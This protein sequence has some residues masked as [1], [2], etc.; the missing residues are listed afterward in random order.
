MTADPAP[1]A[2]P[3]HPLPAL[4]TSELARYRRQL[5]TALAARGPA[6]STQRGCATDSSPCSPSKP[7]APG[8]PF[9]PRGK[10]HDG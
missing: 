5:E 1:V 8:S 3:A 6:A 9:S 7:T 10:H 4:T 2:P